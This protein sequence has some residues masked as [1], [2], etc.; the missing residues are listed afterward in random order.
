[1]IFFVPAYEPVMV[2]QP[3]AP[4]SFS[5]PARG[6]TTV[7]FKVTCAQPCDVTANLTVDRPTAKALGLGK[8]LIA[9]SLT[10]HV[11][12]GRTSLTLK[13]KSKARKALLNGPTERTYRARLK[14]TATYGP[15]TAPVS[16]SRQL[17]LKQ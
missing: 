1:M 5:L 17:T 12:A 10:T 6:R 14:A 8:V 2:Q 3:P 4:P 9:G 16:R 15:G 13:L 7:K 11:D